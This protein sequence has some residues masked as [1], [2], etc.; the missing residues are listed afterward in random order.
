MT[1]RRAWRRTANLVLVLMIV[2]A[3]ARA[4]PV[5]TV[6]RVSKVLKAG[7]LIEIAH[8]S[9]RHIRGQLSE[10]TNCSIV[11]TLSGM[12]RTTVTWSEVKKIRRL[13]PARSSDIAAAARTCESRDCPPL[14]L[15]VSSMAGVAHGFGAIFNGP[16]TVYRAPKQPVV[17]LRQCK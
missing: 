7:D 6:D 17:T 9:G 5:H 11:V 14:M 16:R 13:R 8:T 3:V 2:P 15:V 10:L 12:N 4:A 1:A